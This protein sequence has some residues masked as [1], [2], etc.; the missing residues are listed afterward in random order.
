MQ[1]EAGHDFIENQ[2]GSL[3]G[4]EFANMLQIA[5]IRH[6]E[7]DI[8]AIGLKND[9]GNLA[10]IGGEPGGKC[11]TVVEGQ[12]HRFTRER[13]GHAGAVRIAMRQGAGAGF[14]E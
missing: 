8:A 2:Q 14:D 9:A 6:D 11:L 13:G 4:A 5:G 3:A 12:H 1:P 7:T 10:G